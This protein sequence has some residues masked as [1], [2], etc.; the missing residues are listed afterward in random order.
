MTATTST[1]KAAPSR[2]PVNM[3]K[4]SSS[5]RPRAPPLSSPAATSASEVAATG[6]PERTSSAPSHPR[7]S[8][9]RAF[10][11]R[12]LP[13]WSTPSVDAP[14]FMSWSAP[15][16]RKRPA[17]SAVTRRAH[18]TIRLVRP[19]RASTLARVEALTSTTLL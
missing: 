9:E 6:E 10:S 14:V 8:V 18:T 17:S 16:K 19:P 15:T 13:G 12:T 2:E 5:L 11:T 3:V 1:T 4:P 7:P